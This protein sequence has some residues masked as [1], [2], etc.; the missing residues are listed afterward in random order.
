MKNVLMIAYFYPPLNDVGTL[1]TTG[2]AGHLR[3]FGWEPFILTV[4]NPDR[5][6]CTLDLSQRANGENVYRSRSILNYSRFA[7]RLNGLLSKMTR[8]MGGTLEHELVPNLLLIP[9]YACGWI[10]LTVLKGLQLIRDNNIDVI[11]A[12][13]KPNSAGIAGAIL[14]RISGKPLVIDLRDPWRRWAVQEIVGNQSGVLTRLGDRWKDRLDTVLETKALAQAGRIIFTTRETLEA[15]ERL[16]PFL[17]E[18]FAVIHNGYG[19]GFFTERPPE[20][21]GVFTIVYSGSYYYYL[22][23]GEVFFQVLAKLNKDPALKG[24]IRFLYIGKSRIVSK[25]IQKYGLE[26]SADCTGYLGRKEAIALMR[27]ASVILLRNI[28]PHLSTKLFEGLASGIPFLA[29]TGEGEAGDLV[30]Q[31]SPSSILVGERNPDALEG[32]IRM[33]YTRWV[34]GQL[35]REVNEEFREKFSKYRLT[36]KFAG[37]LD[38]CLE[39][40]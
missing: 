9:D 11:F 40:R 13:C 14:S 28:K 21:F 25:M 38:E 17:K 2:F 36:E 34:K 12:T 18:R 19:D 20:P 33:L 29:L 39:P 1:R 7:W 6:A 31:Y 24:K 32:A 16:Y 3:S 23:Q 26:G 30:R 10:P 15:Y 8:A 4:K 27:R 5:N 35:R 22:D 37:I